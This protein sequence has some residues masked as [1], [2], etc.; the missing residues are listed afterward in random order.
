MLKAFPSEIN[1]KWL[2]SLYFQSIYILLKNRETYPKKKGD[3]MVASDKKSLGRLK[4]KTSWIKKKYYE[5]DKNRTA[6]QTK[7][8]MFSNIP[9]TSEIKHSYFFAQVKCFFLFRKVFFPE[10]IRNCFFIW[11]T[12]FFG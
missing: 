8:E 11:K 4:A 2:F 1:S 10:I 5:M 3:N 12:D 9:S 6:S 7:T